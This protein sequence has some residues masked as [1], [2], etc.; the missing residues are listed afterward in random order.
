MRRLRREV[1]ARVLTVGFVLIGVLTLVTVA[2]GSGA[3][4]SSPARGMFTKQ[5]VV[6]A[7]NRARHHAGP[8][9]KLL[10]LTITARTALFT[11]DSGSR[12]NSYAVNIPR[13]RRSPGPTL[14]LGTTAFALSAIQPKRPL[15]YSRQSLTSR[16]SVGSSLT[17]SS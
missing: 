17:I 8:D 10:D 2:A 4:R 12:R 14:V 13:T 9:V 7:V 16:D 11:Y 5:N 3:G 6:R 1:L 15:R